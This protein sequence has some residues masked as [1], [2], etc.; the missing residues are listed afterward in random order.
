MTDNWR[1]MAGDTRVWIYQADRLMTQ[2]EIQQIETASIRFLDEWTSHGRNMLADIH[3]FNELFIVVFA[4]EEKTKASGCGIDKSVR[5]IQEIGQ[6]FEI[7]FFNRLNVACIVNNQIKIFPSADIQK[8]IEAGNI[9]E[10]TPVY[11]NLV[12]TK[13]EIEKNWEVPLSNSWVTQIL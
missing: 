11:N 8:E 9:S 3:V 5:F 13:D 2:S 1:N 12:K 7:D 10:D 4:D 6:Q